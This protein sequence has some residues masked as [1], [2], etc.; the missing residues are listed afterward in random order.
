MIF[1]L[2]ECPFSRF[3][4]YF[5]VSMTTPSGE[6]GDELYLHSHHGGSVR[7][8]R[9]EPVVDGDAVPFDVQATP[10]EVV[11]TTAGGG[12][13][14][15]VIAPLQTVRVR[16]RGVSLRLEM[17][18]ERWTT[19]YELPG[20]A[21]AFNMSNHGV[22]LALD[23]IHG[24]LAV[25]APWGRLKGFCMESLRMIATLSP[26]TDGSFEAAIDEFA[27]TWVRPERPGFD[28]CRDEV[29]TEFQEW[30]VGLPEVAPRHE[31]ARDLAGYVNWSAV[32]EPSGYL[33]RRTMLMSKMSMCNV[34][35]WDNAFNAMA[36][37]WHDP[38]LAWDQFM[39]MADQQDE[40]GKCPNSMNDRDIRYTFANLPIQGWALQRMWNENPALRTPERMREAYDYLAGWSAWLCNRTWPGDALPYCSH[41]F[42]NWDNATMF[43]GGVPVV[44]PDVSAYLIIQLE[45]LVEIAREL[46]RTDDAAEWQRRRD[47]LLDELI[48]KLWR[49]DH[50]VGLRRPSGEAVECD[51]LLVCMPIVLGR[52]LPEA[53][54]TALLARLRE[55]LTPWGLAT[56]KPTSSEYTERGYWRGPIW[57]PS[58]M[59]VVSG[60][61]DIGESE[62]ARSIA[63]AFCDMCVRHGF[64]E[65]FDAK[66]G[67]GHFDPAYTWTS[68]VFMI[69]ASQYRK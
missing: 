7:A 41:G 64:Y 37:A 62:L 10:S 48:E 51:S 16:G 24:E 15:I 52:R 23:L 25:D 40:H 3:G 29:A 61:E 22:Q 13:I 18:K 2:A 68:S 47:Q 69:F 46:G 31:P 9:I 45:T 56:E 38:D 32:V 54:R 20:D 12:R 53:M 33:R 63:D 49:T 67:E 27:T 50:F 6:P 58:T 4:S 34:Y 28:A 17:P 42:D 19:S 30:S 26:G 66:T 57:A 55:H 11:L 65:N 43:D 21:W 39:V 14:E 5:S 36:H 44:T 59:L 1:N 60:L 35:H 8:F